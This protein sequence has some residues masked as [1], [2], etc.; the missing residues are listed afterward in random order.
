MP[1]GR[2][3]LA[4][5]PV[6]PFDFLGAMKSI[7]DVNLAKFLDFDVPL[8]TGITKD[9]FPASLA[10]L[11]SKGIEL[12]KQDYTDLIN[13]VTEHLD[14]DMLGAKP[15]LIMHGWIDKQLKKG[16]CSKYGGL[17]GHKSE[18]VPIVVQGWM[19]ATTILC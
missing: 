1:R 19:F 16:E 10:W 9:L 2:L 14:K 13:K 18:L 17:V 4:L 11:A 5:H 12:P 8:Y 3:T 7:N 6:L 15:C